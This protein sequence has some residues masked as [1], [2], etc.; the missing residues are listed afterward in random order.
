MDAKTKRS[1]NGW[2]VVLISA[3]LGFIM[4]AAYPQFSMTVEYL[5]DEIHISQSVLLFSD[6]IKS[7][8]IV[9]SML[10]SGMLY[11][12]LGMMKLFLLGLICMA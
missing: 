1:K 6:T 10:V 8:F 11:K 3:F 2:D 4:A 7:L 9:I 12:K 5:S